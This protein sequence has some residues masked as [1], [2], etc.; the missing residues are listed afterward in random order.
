MPT[1]TASCSRW[2]RSTAL[3]IDA[4]FR[5]SAR[6]MPR[7]C[8]SKRCWPRRCSRLRW[9][10]NVT[11]SLAVLRQQG[12]QRVPPHLQRFRSDDLLAAVFPETVGCLENHSGDVPIPDHPLVRQT[13]H[14]CKHEAMDIDG[15]LD[16]LGDRQAG[17]STFVG[18]DTREPSPFCYELL[19]ANPYAFLDGAALEER[20]TRAVATRRTLSGDELRDLARLDPEAIAEVAA[21]AWPTVR[22]A[23]E[24]HDALM[25]LVTLARRKCPSWNDWFERTGPGRPGHHRRAEAGGHTA[26]IAAERWPVHAA[27]ATVPSRRRRSLGPQLAGKLDRS[28]AWVELVRG[29]VQHSGP[30]TRRAAGRATGLEPDQVV[31]RRSKRSK[32]KAWCC[33]GNSR[34]RA[35]GDAK[36]ARRTGRVVRTPAAGPDSSPH[37]P[38]PAAPRFNRSNRP[39]SGGSSSTGRALDGKCRSGAGRTARREAVKLLQGFEMPPARGSS[40]CWPPRLADYDPAWLDQLFLS[41]EAVWGRL[42]PPVRAAGGHARHG[43]PTRSD[44]HLADAPRKI[45]IGCCP[46]DRGERRRFRAQPTPGGAGNTDRPRGALFFGELARLTELLDG[47]LESALR[48]LAALGLVT[49]DAFAAVRRIAGAER[50]QASP[51]PA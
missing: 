51:P 10:W 36:A 11:R 40:A 15:F 44:A 33:G 31:C 7:D 23:D 8:W 5:C 27:A 2:G 24:L 39:T 43:S 13:M 32:G 19:N 48:E 9:R 47:H 16:L 50:P 46:L 28:D 37:D 1:T 34:R 3:P 25:S 26:G 12:G 30:T 20:R 18:R 35:S 21:E 42:R 38:G 29:R 17:E 22:D 6:T 14:D 49:C 45:S 4:L 41:G